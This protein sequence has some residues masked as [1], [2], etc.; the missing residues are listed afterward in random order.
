MTEEEFKENSKV[1]T[2]FQELKS[3][4]FVA[5]HTIKGPVDLFSEK[6]SMIFNHYL[7]NYGYSG[8]VRSYT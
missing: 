8:L 2:G 1:R 7:I 3:G 5:K 4:F 6:K